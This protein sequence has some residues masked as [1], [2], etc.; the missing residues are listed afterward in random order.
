MPAEGEVGEHI[1][2]VEE[3]SLI[4]ITTN[5]TV[6][7]R[8]ESLVTDRIEVITAKITDQPIEPL[9]CT[10]ME[11]GKDPRSRTLT[12]TVVTMR[13]LVVHCHIIERVAMENLEYIG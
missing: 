5:I 2:K 1:T 7:K 8:N 13:I 11:M 3:V 4:T 12:K 6:T 10:T 9:K